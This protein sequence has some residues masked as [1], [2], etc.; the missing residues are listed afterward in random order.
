MLRPRALLGFSIGGT[1]NR[2]NPRA[3]DQA[4]DI[5]TGCT[6][7]ISGYDP[8]VMIRNEEIVLLVYSGFVKATEDR[9]KKSKRALSPNDEAA[10]VTSR[11]KVKK[12]EATDIN[13]FNTR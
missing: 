3:I 7:S 9:I 12:V 8:R 6:T 5:W 13:R 1:N 11:G 4:G 10:D 2:L